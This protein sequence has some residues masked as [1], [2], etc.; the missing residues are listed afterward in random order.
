MDRILCNSGVVEVH[1]QGMCDN[2]D[3]G[4]SVSHGEQEITDNEGRDNMTVTRI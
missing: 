2:G 3:N 1:G 4:D